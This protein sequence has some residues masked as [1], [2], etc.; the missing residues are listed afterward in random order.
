MNSEFLLNIVVWY[1]FLLVISVV[2]FAFVFF[3]KKQENPL[4]F[5]LIVFIWIFFSVCLLGLRDS[6]IGTDSENY[7]DMYE[8]ATRGEGYENFNVEYLFYILM[9]L[10]GVFDNYHI[11]FLLVHLIFIFS[12][13]YFLKLNFRYFSFVFLIYLSTFYYYN[14]SIN[15]IRNSLAIPFWLISIYFFE[16]KRWVRGGLLFSVSVLFH[17]SGFFILFAYLLSK[18]SSVPKLVILWVVVSFFSAINLDILITLLEATPLGEILPLLRYS[19][20]VDNKEITDYIVG[21]RLDFWAI[22]F[23][24]I[25]YLYMTKSLIEGSVWVRLFLGLSILSVFAYQFPYSDRT[26]LFSWFL[27]PFII[28]DELDKVNS[29]IEII[30]FKTISV[31]ILLSC[32]SFLL[33]SRSI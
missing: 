16:T 32:F 31:C 27:I 24:F 23:L 14:L 26:S 7:R 28:F 29:K 25:L 8:M 4:F 15:I 11:F 3:K 2:Y 22:N 9:T 18:F 19:V 12:L 21:F 13:I 1:Y 30:F 5:N 17:L 20:Y 10:C 6:S 33:F